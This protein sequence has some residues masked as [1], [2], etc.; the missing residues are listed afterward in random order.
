MLTVA[1]PA[2]RYNYWLGGKDNFAVD[3]ASGDLIAARF[4]TIPIAVRENRRFMC[5]AVTALAEDG[6]DEF[7]DIGT[8]LPTEPN[9]HEVAHTVNPAAKVVYVDNSPLVLTHAR[10][11][12]T[13][14]PGYGEIAY[15]NGD[16][17]HP[18]S[19]LHHPDLRKTLDLTRPV[20]LT[21][22]AVMHFI[23]DD[24]QAN[25]IVDELLHA[26]PAGS[27]LALTHLTGDLLPTDVR[28]DFDSIN[29]QASIPMRH[30]SLDQIN[31]FV[32]GLELAEP[33]IVPINRWR[34]EAEPEPR[35]TDNDTAVYGAIAKLP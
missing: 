33:G 24:T 4:P 1:D 22:I 12:L 28:D 31:R 15:I 34:A 13:A 20:G 21:L 32:T 23:T 35:P 5:R 7:L 29:N 3:R 11:L 6:I 26:L 27:Y 9:L 18:D 14:A 25:A 10:A 19:I 2:R 16:L 17:R 30:R 8:G